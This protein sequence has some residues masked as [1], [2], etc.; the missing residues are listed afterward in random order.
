MLDALLVALGGAL[1]SLIRFG[2]VLAIRPHSPGFPSGTLAVNV[3]GCL[4]IGVLAGVWTMPGATHDRLR[5]LVFVGVLGGFTTFSSFALEF[6]HLAREGRVGAA[7]TYAAL[8]NVLGLAAA[9]VGL[10]ITSRG[11]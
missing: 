2:V 11:N 10:A 5:L 7:L 9:L 6:A 8:S 1:G 3:L 4:V